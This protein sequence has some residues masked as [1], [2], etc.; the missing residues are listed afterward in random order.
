MGMSK[1]ESLELADLTGVNVPELIVVRSD[2]L[3]KLEELE[4]FKKL[5]DNI[6]YAVRSSCKLEDSETE[7]HAG[8]FKT[9]LNVNKSD[10]KSKVDEVVASYN[11]LPGE[12]IIQEMVDADLSGIVFTANPIGILNEMVIT[13]G[14]GLG[15]NVVEDK[16]DTTT[17]FYN[18]DDKKYYFSGDEDLL[19]SEVL[20]ALIDE[21]EFIQLVIDEFGDLTKYIDI[22][23]AI[24]DNEVFIL[25]IR[26]ITTLKEDAEVIILDNSNIV[27]SYPGISLP[28][29]QD[30]VTE[31][32]YKVF[33][34]LILRVTQDD[35]LVKKLD[36][37]LQNMVDTC[38]G[39][40][41]YRISNWYSVLDIM[42]FSR[43][44]ISIWQEML[45]VHNTKVTKRFNI[46]T[47][48]KLKVIKQ[49]VAL[50]KSNQSNMKILN[51]T[52]NSKISTYRTLIEDCNS[53]VQLLNVYKIIMDNLT[54]MW[55]IT[56]IN[57]MYTFIFT[58]LAGKKAK[59]KL[60]NIQNLESMKPVHKL[61][62]IVE[63][64]SIHGDDGVYKIFETDYID[65][66]G[67]RCIGELKLETKTYRT[68]PELLYD[69]IKD[70]SAIITN[71]DTDL[72]KLSYQLTSKD[73]IKNEDDKSVK[74]GYFAKKA[75]SGIKNRETS[76]MNRTRIFGLARD[77][78]LQVGEMLAKDGYI[79]NYR[80]VFYLKFNELCEDKDYRDLVK[81][82]KEQYKQFENIP[83]FN[84]LE[85]LERV[86]DKS[87]CNIHH[88]KIDEHT[89]F[90]GVG[91]SL[92]KVVG[93][94]IVIDNPST[95]IDTHNKII[96]TESTD[97]G[98]VFLIKN[99]LGIVTERGSMLSHTAIVTRELGKPAVV[100]VKGIMDNLKTGDKIELDAYTGTVKLL[101]D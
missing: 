23:F 16:I 2:E 101:A 99:S 31:I 45:G 49:I 40:M 74:Y 44:I 84:R 60:K 12:V 52:F 39:R 38:N 28:L 32:Y 48:T 22:E 94:V 37:D 14:K 90:F 30:F 33:R 7:S 72:V 35:E 43:K 67:D 26:P 85:F 17:Y 78:M 9:F 20:K 56:L 4:D 54:S 75:K 100:N 69:Y 88:K 80:D 51:N 92:G 15:N 77:I 5:K 41:Y 18:V 91:S 93:E 83:N 11:G 25:Q 1:A 36:P 34:Q 58:A 3:D 13:V 27:E 73:D 50:A 64:Y 95:T 79:D 76:R 89:E 62:K 82:R 87:L 61:N 96:V 29:T 70:K 8:E 53:K 59:A 21:V 68:N 24:K 86:T 10:I 65:T 46:S 81:L 42:P 71:S 6:K 63:L 19:S 55:D 98:W 97:P 57:D 66:Y 47:K